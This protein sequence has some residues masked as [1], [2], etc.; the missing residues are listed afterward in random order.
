[1]RV[2]YELRKPRIPFKR[3]TDTALVLTVSFVSSSP[4]LQECIEKVALL[5]QTHQEETEKLKNEHQDKVDELIDGHKNV[6]H[7]I[8]DRHSKERLVGSATV[9][10][11]LFLT[12]AHPHPHP[13]TAARAAGAQA[14]S[15][16]P[17]RD[18]IMSFVHIFSALPHDRF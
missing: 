14:C 16:A 3:R 9:S 18:Q 15:H 10:G 13:H 2:L 8:D 17:D 4:L 12:D 6:L 7:Q 5:T 1:M 11:F